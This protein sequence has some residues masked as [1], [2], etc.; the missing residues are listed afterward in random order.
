MA[1][2]S[3]TYRAPI[4]VTLAAALIP[5]CGSVSSEDGSG[6]AG[7]TETGG[8]SS[9]GGKLGTGGKGSGGG[10]STGGVNTGGQPTGGLGGQ[11][12]GGSV[13]PPLP[14][15]PNDYFFPQITCVPEARCEMPAD[16]TSGE[17]R[18]FHFKCSGT[19]MTW[20]FEGGDCEN[21][22]EYCEATGNT[23]CVDDNWLY[24]GQGGNP[25]GPCPEEL[26]A[27]GSSCSAGEGFG[28]DRGNCGY[29]CGDAWTVI[30]CVASGDEQVSG[31]GSWESDGAC[32]GGG[33]DGS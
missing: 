23:L 26:P 19:G 25:P 10:T 15:C 16:C 22:Y 29:P 32:S 14:A 20:A 27:E 11:A 12:T 13:E 30:G 28:A 31:P 7:G 2:T 18:S 24:Q 6:G 8:S 1:R 33:A 17:Q 5:A 3:R 4:V 21:P 9:T